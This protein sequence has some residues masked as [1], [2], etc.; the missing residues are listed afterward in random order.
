VKIEILNPI[1]HD[2]RRFERGIVDLPEDVA[3]M[4]LKFKHAAH[5]AAVEESKVEKSKS[6]V[7]KV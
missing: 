4:F 3:K 7:K 1:E 6:S 2:G 5:P